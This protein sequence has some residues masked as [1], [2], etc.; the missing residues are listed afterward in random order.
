MTVVILPLYMVAQVTVDENHLSF[1]FLDDEW[2]KKKLATGAISVAHEQSDDG[3]PVL[4]ASTADLQ[5]L[6]LHHADDK[7]AF[8]VRIGNFQ[9]K[10]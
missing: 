9:R 10:Q 1:D 8:S 3:T 7:E 5:Q 6:I 2:V 4:T